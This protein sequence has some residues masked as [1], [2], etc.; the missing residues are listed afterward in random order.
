MIQEPRHHLTEVLAG[1]EL[2]GGEGD[3][4]FLPDSSHHHAFM[5]LHQENL[6]KASL[7]HLVA[8]GCQLLLQCWQ[9][10]DKKIKGGSGMASHE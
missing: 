3:V 1:A 5:V 6:T 7:L 9:Q 2:Y 4:G 10:E 8:R